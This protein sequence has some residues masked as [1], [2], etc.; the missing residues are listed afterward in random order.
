MEGKA[1]DTYYRISGSEGLDPKAD[2]Q[3]QKNQETETYKQ[4]L[5]NLIEEN[6]A[7]FDENSKHVITCRYQLDI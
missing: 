6:A 3:N 4:S 7:L 2:N 1:Q 5:Q